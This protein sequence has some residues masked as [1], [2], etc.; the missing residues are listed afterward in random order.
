MTDR[1]WIRDALERW[2]GPLVAYARRITGDLER[3]RDAVQDTFLKLC[4]RDRAEVQGHLAEW[5]FTVCRNQALDLVRKERPMTSLEHGPEETRPAG[6]GDGD[7]AEAAA[8][9]ES[10]D[11]ALVLLDAL[12]ERQRDALR[13]KF[14][15]G[16]SYKEIAKVMDTSI[17]NVGYLIH[18]GLAALR[19]RLSGDVQGESRGVLS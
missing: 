10:S 19:E 16:L 11:R 15:G 8:E 7:P 18:V 9:R 1:Q 17:G 14:Q 13:L 4:T 12:P 6:R 3:A 2:E 5:L